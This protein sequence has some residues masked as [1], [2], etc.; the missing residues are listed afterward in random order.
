[1]FGI[2][3]G[4][5]DPNYENHELTN[6]NATFRHL[7]VIGDT[8]HDYPQWGS[9]IIVS[10]A[11]GGENVAESNPY[12]NSPLHKWTKPVSGTYTIEDIEMYN[13]LYGL[14]LT[15]MKDSVLNI[16]G[17]PKNM[18][19]ADGVTVPIWLIDISNSSVDLSYLNADNCDGG[20]W[21]DQGYDAVWGNDLGELVPETLPDP[22][23]FFFHH[24]NISNTPGGFWASIELWNYGGEIGQSVGNII[25]ANNKISVTDNNPPYEGIF[26]YFIDNL[27][28]TNNII[29]GR[30]LAGIWIE[31]F[32]TPASGCLLQGNNLNNFDAMLAPIYLGSGTSNCTVIG[33]NNKVNVFDE[34][35]ENI[36]TGVNNQGMNIGLS[37]SDAL[38][39]KREIIKIF[40]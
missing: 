34:G 37:L 30:G 3:R 4:Y 27:Y 13:A 35:T 20:V 31:P 38:E 12:S 7:K 6:I 15:S 28:V 39:R 16:G 9:S 40:H 18:I 2:V 11:I 19:I 25:I 36:L 1:V 10:F 23:N 33:G 5:L 24:N 8:Y 32:G 22:S 17:S 29:T 14:Y 21:L 26:S